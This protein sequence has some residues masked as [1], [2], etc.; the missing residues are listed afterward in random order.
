M[1]LTVTERN[2]KVDPRI[3]NSKNASRATWACIERLKQLDVLDELMKDLVS[4]KRE[5]QF[6]QMKP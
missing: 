3:V 4:K 6:R 1:A 2:N 5:N